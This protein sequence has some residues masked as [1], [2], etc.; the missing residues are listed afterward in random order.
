MLVEG[1]ALFRIVSIGNLFFGANIVAGFG[2]EDALTARTTVFKAGTIFGFFS[3][4]L[5]VAIDP[6]A[7]AV[8]IRKGGTEDNNA[9]PVK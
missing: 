5:A 2:R 3:D 9:A 7:A 4:E 6:P 8:V 1:I